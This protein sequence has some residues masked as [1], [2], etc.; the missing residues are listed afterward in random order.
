MAP[1]GRRR[2]RET[3]FRRGPDKLRNNYKQSN[4]RVIA[5]VEA[6]KAARP[7]FR[8]AMRDPD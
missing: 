1:H 2:A 6:T 3:T 4:A 7:A 5:S 8:Y